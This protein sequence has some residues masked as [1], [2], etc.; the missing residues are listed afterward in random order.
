[1]NKETK[2]LTPMYDSISDDDTAIFIEN[3]ANKIMTDTVS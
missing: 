3:T 2:S 1:M